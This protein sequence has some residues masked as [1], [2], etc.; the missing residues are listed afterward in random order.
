MKKIKA[1]RVDSGVDLL[2]C[3][4]V[5]VCVCICVYVCVCVV[6]FWPMTLF[7]SV[8]LS[9][10]FPASSVWPFDITESFAQSS[11]GEFFVYH[12]IRDGKNTTPRDHSLYPIERGVFDANDRNLVASDYCKISQNNREKRYVLRKEK[13]TNPEVTLS[14]PSPLRPHPAPTPLMCDPLSGALC[15]E[16]KIIGLQLLLKLDCCTV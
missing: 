12:V 2:P 8:D 16:V 4:Y 11:G 7:R 10:W 15:Q 5:C 14:L 9:N 1:G 3:V 13:E 6:S